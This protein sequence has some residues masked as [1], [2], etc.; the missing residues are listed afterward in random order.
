MQLKREHFL[1][2]KFFKL[3]VTRL[4]LKEVFYSNVIQ[5]GFVSNYNFYKM[6]IRGVD[7]KSVAINLSC[8]VK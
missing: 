4:Y 7:N 8:C 5:L 3:T 1:R 6:I 2:F